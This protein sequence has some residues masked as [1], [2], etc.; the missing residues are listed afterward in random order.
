VVEHHPR[1]GRVAV[2]LRQ[3]E[4]AVEVVEQRRRANPGI[5]GPAA[6]S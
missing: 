4:D 3:A 6:G 5:G 1:R 2:D